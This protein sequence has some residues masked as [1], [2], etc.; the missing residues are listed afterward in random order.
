MEMEIGELRRQRDDAQIQLEELRQK[1]QG[2]QQQN[3]V[4]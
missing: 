2:D 4:S 3:K 1:L